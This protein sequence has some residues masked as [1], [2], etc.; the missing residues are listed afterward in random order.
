MFTRLINCKLFNGLNPLQIEEL[1]ASIVYQLKK[2][3]R[4]DIIAHNGE[5]INNQMI[6]IEGSAKGEMIDFNGKT[7]KIEDIESPR[8]L[9]PAFLFG[10]DN[11]YPVDII[12][13]DKVVIISIPKEY[14]LKLLGNSE[15]VLLNYLD[16]ISS[17][18]QFLTSKIRLLSFH[19]IKGKLAQ[20]ILS[21]SRKMNSDYI[22]IPISQNELSELFGVA[23]PSLS[24]ALR[25]MND[26]G[27]IIARG[28]KVTVVDKGK[29]S[30]LLA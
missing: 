19:S 27:L 24:R 9:A 28:R 2:F 16:I 4:G 25:E 12:A 6:I 26:D 21:L 10:I 20:Y 22:E 1:L 11:T 17:R 18:T 7:I 14:F 3:E 13:N 23:R 30:A 5:K 8:S 29:L 15:K